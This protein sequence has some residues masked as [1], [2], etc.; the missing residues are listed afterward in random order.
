LELILFL[1]YKKTARFI[2]PFFVWR[3]GYLSIGF[4]CNSVLVGEGD[5]RSSPLAGDYCLGL[6]AKKQ[7]S[8]SLLIRRGKLNKPPKSSLSG[9]LKYFAP[10]KKGV[11]GI[12]KNFKHPH[13]SLSGG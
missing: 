2:R 8:P 1:F 11:W 13:T 5:E 3:K 7:T 12:F 9:G 6:G 4:Y 10:L